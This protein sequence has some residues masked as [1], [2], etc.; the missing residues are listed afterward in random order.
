MEIHR[1][2]LSLCFTSLLSIG[3][4]AS[5]GGIVEV[6]SSASLTAEESEFLSNFYSIVNQTNQVTG[7]Y[8]NEIG[9]WQSGEYDDQEMISI[10]DSYLPVYDQ[11]I[12]S[13]SSFSVPEKFQNALD[14]YLKS[15]SS[16]Q[17]SYSLFRDFLLT[18]DASLDETST[19][20]LTNAT[21]YELESFTSINEQTV[22]LQ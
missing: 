2:F 4:L 8:H 21:E 13:A 16:E 14:L 10:T 17:E 15:L 22:P 7:E 11:L 18:G 19:D 1:N 6:N 3:I 12:N 9:K 5:A 20:L